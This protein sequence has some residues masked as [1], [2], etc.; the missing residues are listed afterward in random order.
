MVAAPPPPIATRRVQRATRLVPPP[1]HGSPALVPR[2]GGRRA[3]AAVA[4]RLVRA[5]CARFPGRFCVVETGGWSECFHVLVICGIPS[6][7]AEREPLAM[8]QVGGSLHVVA[9]AD[10]RKLLDS[11]TDFRAVPWW[12]LCQ[13]GG[14]EQGH[15][16]RCHVLDLTV[17]AIAAMLGL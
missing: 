16:E 8:L 1:P 3:Q 13:K 15:A 11:P 2:P 6:S 12:R 14:G 10:G 9:R 17:R 7:I 4:W 5:L